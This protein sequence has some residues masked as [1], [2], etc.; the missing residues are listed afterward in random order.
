ME[1]SFLY[2][3][4]ALTEFCKAVGGPQAKLACPRSPASPRNRP[5]ALSHGIGAAPGKW[6]LHHAGDEYQ[7]TDVK[8]QPLGQICGS[9]TF[10]T[11]RSDK[12]VFLVTI[13]LLFPSDTQGHHGSER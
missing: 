12:Y 10:C 8:S 7:R 13:V 6:P 1:G 5:L 4:A 9:L 3:S 2:C 11:G